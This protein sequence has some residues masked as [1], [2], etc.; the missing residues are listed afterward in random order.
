MST[1]SYIF[2][3]SSPNHYIGTYCHFDGY[4]SGVGTTL[5]KH[6]R[7]LEKIQQL[8]ALGQLSSLDKEC[9]PPPHY[10]TYSI[11]GEKDIRIPGYTFAY[12][13]DRGDELESPLT[14]NSL[15]EMVKLGFYIYVWKDNQWLCWVTQDDVKTQWTPLAEKLQKL[16]NDSE[17][18]RDYLYLPQT[19]S[20]KFSLEQYM[21]TI[22]RGFL[23]TEGEN[24]HIGD[25]V[26]L[27][28]K[29]DK[30]YYQFLLKVVDIADN[31]GVKEGYQLL[32]LSRP[33]QEVAWYSPCIKK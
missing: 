25:Y 1:N 26:E 13:R 14:A 10:Q 30:H 4:L 28:A 27:Q 11:T 24:Y 15:E 33:P 5:H 16:Q 20:L 29:E 2:Y 21:E 6:Y 22:R 12:H 19:Y 32:I 18:N 3:E 17:S 31:P 8:I 7:D 9:T 23:L